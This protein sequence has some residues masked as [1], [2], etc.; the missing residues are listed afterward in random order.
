[1]SL[2]IAIVDPMISVSEVASKHEA[3]L[4]EEHSIRPFAMLTS[5]LNRYDDQ[6]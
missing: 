2:V 4:M 3:K 6:N 1:L 5:P